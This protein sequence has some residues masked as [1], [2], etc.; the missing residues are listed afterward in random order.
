MGRQLRQ[1]KSVAKIRQPILKLKK[2]HDE[3][4]KLANDISIKGMELKKNLFKNQSVS[5]LPKNETVSLEWSFMNQLLSNLHK[6][7]I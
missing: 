7:F 1:S 3:P 6:E 2:R 4:L 5:I